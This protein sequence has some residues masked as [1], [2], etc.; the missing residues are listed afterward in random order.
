[1]NNKHLQE[2]VEALE[3]LKETLEQSVKELENTVQA[4]QKKYQELFVALQKSTDESLK[5][6][7]EA[8]AQGQKA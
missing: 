4:D 7:M 2:D 6:Q 5:Q 1:M 8:Q 3:K